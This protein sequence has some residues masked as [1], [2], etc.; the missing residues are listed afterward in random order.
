[1]VDHPPKPRLTLRVGIT[2]HRPNKLSGPAVACVRKQLPRMFAA[3]E[4]AAGNILAANAEFYA[5]QQPAFRLVAGFAEGADQIAVAACPPSWQ[6]EA[7][8]PFP[9]EEYLKDFETSA[10]GD[11]RDVREEFRRSLSRASAVT[12]LALQQ[13]APRQ[14]GYVDAGSYLLRQIDVLIAV[15]DGEPPKPGG[16]GAIVKLAYEGGI[17]VAW[18]EI[19]PDEPAG[20]DAVPRLITGFDDNGAPLAADADCTD[21]PL[22]TAIEPIFAAPSDNDNGGTA[23]AGLARFLAETWPNHCYF[24]F[25]DFLRRLVLRRRPRLVITYDSFEKRSSDWDAFIRKCPDIQ[26]LRD[27][28]KAVLLPRFIWADSLAVHYS[29]LYRSAYV[30]AYYLSALAALVALVGVTFHSDHGQV[31]LLLSE[32]IAIS[33]IMTIVWV[34]KHRLWHER[35]LEY[36]AL[37]ETLRHGRFLAFVGEFGG[38]A[39]YASATG[40]HQPSWMSWYFRATVREIGLPAAILDGTFQW[41]VLEATLE[42][43]IGG[44]EGQLAYHRANRDSARVIDHVLHTTGVFLFGITVLALFLFIVGYAVDWVYVW[45]TNG[46]GSMALGH[47]LDTA[48]PILVIVTVGFSSLGAALAGI[49][50]HGDFEGSAERSAHMVDQL[51]AHKNEYLSLT[52]RN[53][54]LDTTGQ[55]LIRTARIMSEDL[56]AWKDLYGRKRL[57]LG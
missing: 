10:A 41:H 38:V 14:Q 5:R 8:L 37:A 28:L 7:I 56:A 12:E 24:T 45:A 27:R 36:R 43:E 3:I 57:T 42:E 19:P 33:L 50:V 2:G 15:W 34:G 11:G 13:G 40:S 17:P 21:G 22:S 32:F 55:T 44:R 52:A 49:R 25:Y 39:H 1:M 51:E 29:H 20:F 30:V 4:K 16:T 48:K 9:V 6:V 46:Q 54:N 53:A 35:W 47:A 31:I 26:N 18:L 23:R